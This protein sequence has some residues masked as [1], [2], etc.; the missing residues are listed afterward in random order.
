MNDLLPR[1]IRILQDDSVQN[2]LLTGCGGGFD[3]SHSLLIVPFIVQMNKKLI[4]VSNCFSTINLSY[5]DYETVYTR[6]NR[7]LAKRI[8]P[9]KAKPNDGYIPEKLFI[10]NVFEHF[11]N[12]DIELYAT[13]AHSMIS[14]VSTDFLTGLCKEKNID[15]VITIDGGSDSIM[16]GDEHEIATVSEDYTSLVT[17][18]NLMHDK[19]LKIKHGM[20]IIVGLGVDRVHGASDASSLRA[21]AE[22][23]RM[24][25]SLGSI[26]INQDSLGFQMYSE[27]LLK[28]KK[29]FPTIVGSFI[30]AAT[31]G[32]FGPTH[33]KVKVSKVPRHFKKSGVPKESIKLFDLDEKGNNHD[34]IKNE[35]VKP[36]T[37]YI[38]PIMAQFYAFD[39]DT[40]LE[41][42]ILAEDARA[43][44]GYQGDTRN[45]LKAKGSILPPE[46]FPTF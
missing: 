30:A 21:V 44:N 18:Q 46:S 6:G 36:S 2:I 29:L 19:K 12:A 22:L 28:S 45:K 34:T 37:T 42:C 16:R 14:T 39:V 9:G 20:L 1:W 11:P 38:W 8:V 43:P 5:C 23:T 24:G 41:R 3:F 25:G 32:Q 7:S 35:R 13:E 26:S 4:I 27:F 33:P 15:C 10:D 40:V 17:V 31:V